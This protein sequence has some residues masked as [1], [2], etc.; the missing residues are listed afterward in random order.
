VKFLGFQEDQALK[1]ILAGAMF[2]VFPSEAYESFGLSIIESFA[3]GKPVI[4]SNLGPI[5]EIIE[6][7][8]NGL[9]FEPGDIEDLTSKI[10][11]LLDHRDLAGKMGRRAREK[12]EKEYNP[13]IYYD[14]IREVYRQAIESNHKLVR[15]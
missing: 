1:A 5:P 8:I 2:T 12:A 7:G 6:E 10:Q 13:Q 15:I 14:R 3:M 9:L 4:G 11:Y